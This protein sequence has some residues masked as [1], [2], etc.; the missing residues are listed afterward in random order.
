MMQ[1]ASRK[2]PVVQ[3]SQGRVPRM[4]ISQATRASS[5]R[6]NVRFGIIKIGSV[7]PNGF[8]FGGDGEGRQSEGYT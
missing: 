3:F 6:E 1:E 2:T 7:L 5:G 4:G 8:P